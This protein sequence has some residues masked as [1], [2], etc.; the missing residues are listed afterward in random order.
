MTKQYLF[1]VAG[2]AKLSKAIIEELLTSLNIPSE[3]IL[4]IQREKLA[5]T[6]F[7]KLKRI[8]VSRNIQDIVNA[9][10]T[11]IADTPTGS[12]GI[13]RDLKKISLPLKRYVDI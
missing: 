9:N 4:W 12:I 6:D 7:F 13:I 2:T 11:I 10:F 5:K 3:K 8:T 1:A